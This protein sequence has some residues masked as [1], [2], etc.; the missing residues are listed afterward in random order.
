M[1]TLYHILSED[2][3]FHLILNALIQMKI[4][5]WELDSEN[6]LNFIIL[7]IYFYFFNISFSDVD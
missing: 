2:F 1:P 5:E 7:K 4:E 3:Q 6:I